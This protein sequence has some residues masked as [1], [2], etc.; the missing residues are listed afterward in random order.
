MQN[1]MSGEQSYDRL[2]NLASSGVGI[3][4]NTPGCFLLQKPERPF[5][6][7]PI[8]R[9]LISIKSLLQGQNDR[10]LYIFPVKSAFKKHLVSQA[11]VNNLERKSQLLNCG[12]TIKLNFRSSVIG[13]LCPLLFNT[14]YER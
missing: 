5:L 1:Y 7:I 11:M 9:F 4:S 3:D 12:N 13:M 10:P 14:E 6:F 2:L 8:F